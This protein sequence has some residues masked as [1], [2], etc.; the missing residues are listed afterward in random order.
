VIDVVPCSFCLDSAYKQIIRVHVNT[1]SVRFPRFG[2]QL[3]PV[4]MG[5]PRDPLSLPC[6][7]IYCLTCIKQW[8]VPGQMHCPL[9]VQEVPDTF[10]LKASDAIR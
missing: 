3:C 4:C 1:A 5:D 10:E 7:H 6:D 8:L 2:V 9:C